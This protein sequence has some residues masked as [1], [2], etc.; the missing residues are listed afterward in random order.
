MLAAKT[1]DDHFYTNNHYARVGGVPVEE[2]NLLEIDFIFAIHFSLYVS[3]DDYQRYYQEVYKHAAS[4][5]CTLCRM[6]LDRK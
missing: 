2:L 4:N 6:N 3:C 5:S 1:F